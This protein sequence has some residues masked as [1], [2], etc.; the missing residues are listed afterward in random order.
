MACE[1]AQ[2]RHIAENRKKREGK[3]EETNPEQDWEDS[4]VYDQSSISTKDLLRG[5]LKVVIFIP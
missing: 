4:A 3:D 5:V 1:E 2:I